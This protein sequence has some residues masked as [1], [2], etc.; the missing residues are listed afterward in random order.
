MAVA[1]IQVPSR[2][3][4]ANGISKAITAGVEYDLLD[5]MQVEVTC[6]DELVLAKIIT[7]FQGK[8]LKAWHT[9]PVV[10]DLPRNDQISL[11]PA[12]RWGVVE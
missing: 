3:R 11:P 4:M 12:C 1:L 10:P 9:K 5:N 7:A 8:I 2:A 6:A